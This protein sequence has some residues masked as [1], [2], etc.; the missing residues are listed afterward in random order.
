MLRQQQCW[1]FASVRRNDVTLGLR[2]LWRQNPEFIENWNT[3]T[4]YYIAKCVG[5]DH[6]FD[7]WQY[8][9]GG[10]AVYTCRET[11]LP[12]LKLAVT[13]L[14]LSHCAAC[15]NTQHSLKLPTCWYTVSTI[16]TSLTVRSS[17]LL[18]LMV[19]LASC[20]CRYQFLYRIRLLFAEDS[21]KW[22]GAERIGIPS[23]QFV[24]SLTW[25]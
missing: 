17:S 13:I 25:S 2:K 3:S 9:F 24:N 1:K 10:G 23:L 11:A 14:Q 18:L 15:S 4:V 16:S 7:C 12:V 8:G 19:T 20:R 6:G 5:D 21:E 22:G